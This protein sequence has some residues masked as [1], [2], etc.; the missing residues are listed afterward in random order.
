MRYINLYIFHLTNIIHIL[1]IQN[2]Y[3]WLGNCYD[4]NE[5]M[6]MLIPRIIYV[7]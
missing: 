6:Y 7:G 4:I 1:F 5:Y 2:L 3:L